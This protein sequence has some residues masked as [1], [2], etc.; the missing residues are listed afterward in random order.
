MV[1]DVLFASCEHPV[2]R[3]GARSFLTHY[4]MSDGFSPTLPPVS[5]DTSWKFAP[6]ATVAQFQPR[7]SNILSK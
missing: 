4:V 5:D 2:H 3:H 7:S 1:E 6:A